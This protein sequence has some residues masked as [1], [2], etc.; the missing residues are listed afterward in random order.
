[1]AWKTGTIVSNGPSGNLSEALKT[2]V[3]TGDAR[4]WSFIENVPAGYSN[5]HREVQRITLADYAAGDSFK[6]TYGAEET[7]AITYSSDISADITAKLTALTG[8]GASSI[9]TTK[10]TTAIYDVMFGFQKAGVYIPW[11]ATLLQVTTPVNCSGS[12][13]KTYAA[14]RES[15]AVAYSVDVF[16][17]AGTGNDANDAATD[18]YF[19]IGRYDVSEVDTLTI[20]TWD[21]GDTFKLTI[22]GHETTAITYSANN[23]ADIQAAIEALDEFAPG[24]VIVRQLSNH[25]ATVGSYEIAFG[26]NAKFKPILIT[27]TSATGTTPPTC[28]PTRTIIGGV[29]STT[30]WMGCSGAYDA[31]QKMIKQ[32]PLYGYSNSA[33]RASDASG[34]LYTGTGWSGNWLPFS[35]Y[36]AQGAAFGA[37]TGN[38]LN[39]TGFS[40]KIK[41]DKNFILFAIRVGTTEYTMYAGLMDTLV[42]PTI[43]DTLPLVLASN[44][45]GTWVTH[46]GFHK[47]P[48]V[49]NKSVENNLGGVFVVPWL[50]TYIYGG[51][52]GNNINDL[53]QDNGVHVTR[54]LCEHRVTQAL[55]YTCGALRGLLKDEVKCIYMG[56]TIQ[57][58]DT[59]TLSNNGT[60]ETWTVMG[61]IDNIYLIT[62][63]V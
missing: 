21:A 38:V 16:K 23:A 19:F 12:V 53:W 15:G 29:V 57:I 36:F 47:L 42:D 35:T 58:G 45:T 34:Y 62:K 6:L 50:S 14:I 30:W 63:A 24:D 48:G 28:T 49:L 26:G 13:A 25:T 18:W 37:G 9:T 1:M 54:V 10:I 7:A 3:G 61:K 11:D 60:P 41:L 59:V 56:G 17:C 44:S 51:N 39:N 2:L 27:L 46:S 8:I 22:N 40:Y 5:L 4:N 32:F 52:N 33:N 55:Y 31:T 43:A 20:N